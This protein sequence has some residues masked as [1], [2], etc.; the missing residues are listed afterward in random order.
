M[1]DVSMLSIVD[2]LIVVGEL[3]IVLVV[4][5]IVSKLVVMEAMR[6]LLQPDMHSY[7][8][9]SPPLQHALLPRH[10]AL[11]SLPLLL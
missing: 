11:F 10:R 7:A 4:M 1:M 8:L 6:S 3:V 9:L 2:E 5:V